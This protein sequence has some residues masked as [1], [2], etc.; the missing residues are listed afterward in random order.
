M[1][2]SGVVRGD[3]MILVGEQRDE[4]AKHLRT[5]RKSVQ[6]QDSGGVV[7]PSL[8]VEDVQFIHTNSLV[9]HWMFR[10]DE[11]AFCFHIF[12]RW[13]LICFRGADSQGGDGNPSAAGT[14]SKRS[15]CLTVTITRAKRHMRCLCKVVFPASGRRAILGDC[16]MREDVCGCRIT[17]PW[18]QLASASWRRPS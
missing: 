9:T 10:G 13:R 18:F 17:F 7:R 2:I 11:G 16:P 14:G 4:V 3:H 1:P 8:A 12:I 15:R 5:G 6:Q